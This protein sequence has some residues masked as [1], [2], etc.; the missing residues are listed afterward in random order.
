ME[1]VIGQ[2]SGLAGEADRLDARRRSRARTAAERPFACDTLL[3]FYGLK[4]ELGP[5][6]E[7]GLNLDRDLIA[8]DTAAFETKRARHLRDRRHL[9]LSRQAE[10]DPVRA[11][12]RR[13]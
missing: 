8:V 9:H 10:A 6:A 4:M 12:T 3:A 2:I 11:S 13:R 5:I 1:L 7:W